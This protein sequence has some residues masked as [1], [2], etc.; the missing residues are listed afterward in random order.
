MRTFLVAAPRRKVE[1]PGSSP[2]PPVPQGS[3]AHRSLF[4]AVRSVTLSSAEAEFFGVMLAAKDLIFHREI[5]ADL[6]VTIDSTSR[7]HCDSKSAV[8]LTLDPVAFKHTKHILR[9]AE[10]L[11]DLV[12]REVITVSHVPGAIMIADICTK[13]CARARASSSWRSCACSI[14][15]PSMAS[16]LSSLAPVC[17]SRSDRA[18][19]AACLVCPFTY[20]DRSSQEGG[21][22]T[23]AHA[24]M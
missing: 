6:G 13:A 2:A 8:D 21:A 10:F 15:S 12:A 5:F 7:M 24:R 17:S 3:A 19:A 16:C 1:G 22:I 4:S 23:T 9:A 14:A 18:R 20:D 11:R